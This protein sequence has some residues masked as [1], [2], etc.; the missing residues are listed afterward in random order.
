MLKQIYRSTCWYKSN[1]NIVN[2]S[3]VNLVAVGQKMTNASETVPKDTIS[4]TLANS[5]VIFRR[6]RALGYVS[7]SVPAAIRYV[8][9]RKDTLITT[10]IGRSFQV[11]TSSHFRL[12]HVGPVH[13]DE[14]TALAMDRAHTFT[15]SNRCIYAWRAGKHQRHVYR[16]HTRNV[17]L[18]LPFGAHLISVDEANVLRVWDIAKEEVYLELQFN[19]E[20]FLISAITHPPAYLNKI[21]LGSKQG[22]LKIWNIKE[23]RLVYTFA[24]F[25][26]KVTCIQPSPA[27]DVVAVGHQDGTIVLLNL[28]FDEVLMKF[29]QDWGQVSQI[30]FRTDGPPIMITA[31]SNGHMALWNLE[32]RKIAGQLQAHE[33][34]VSTAICFHNEPLLFTTSPDNSMKLWIFDMPDNG[35][36]LLRIREGHT[37][38]PLCIRFHGSNGTSILSAGE[39]SALRVFSTISESL[40]KSMGKASYNRKQSKKRNR[41]DG[42]ALRMPPII[43]FTSETTREREWDNIAAIH[44]G[45]IQTTTWSFHKNR[46]G[47]HRLIPQK[48]QNKERVDY[49]TITTSVTLTHCCNFAIIGYSS[50]DVE[51]FNIQSGLHRAS[52]GSPAHKTA[53]RGVV[54]DILNQFVISGCG[55]GLLKFWPFKEK[56]TN[57]IKCLKFTDG[58]SLMRIHRESAMLAVA[59]VNFTVHIIDVDTRVVVRKFEGHTAKLNDMVF[60]PDSR[61]L[62]TASMDSTIKVWDI[63]SSYMIDHFKVDRPCI[64]LSM[65]PNGDFLATAHVNHLGIYLWANKMLFNQIT[66]RSKNPYS[67]APYVGLPISASDEMDVADL[68]ENAKLNEA[69]DDMSDSEVGPDINATYDS[70][71]QLDGDLI[72]LSGVAA[73]RWQNLLDLEIIKK[74]NK[75]KAPPKTPKQA[76]FFLPTV[77]GLEVKFDTSQAAEAM[78]ETDGSRLL[79]PGAGGLSTLTNFGKMLHGAGDSKKYSN[80]IDHLKQLGP[81]MIDFE[82][83]SLHPT[84]GGSYRIMVA[85]LSTIEQMFGTRLNFELAQAYLSVFLR[86]Y[87]IDLLDSVEVI[88]ALERV[89]KAQENSWKVVEDKLLFGL[90]VVTALRNF[91]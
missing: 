70:P 34:L 67:V 75:P 21:V 54:S 86:V 20:E 84:S 64:S 9:R 18:L 69:D 60:S 46:M 14:I 66:L 11:Y 50:G 48:F 19:P 17:H 44:E 24:G 89:S 55:E 31:C 5:S 13:P 76:P 88:Q 26:S 43:E 4:E 47:E 12:L 58:I 81:S 74:R 29:K 1:R 77:A 65:S 41:F 33:D 42:D 56:V 87:G 53:V 90:G 40:N 45:I 8:R 61:W 51:R 63:P 39:D 83:K 91:V 23:N 72:T 71:S 79:Q 80:C 25:G 10:C 82:I 15:A 49:E 35:A 59:L 52:Y 73:S 27:L 57:H 38:P 37:G 2:I 16:G 32:D 36:R 22:M 28:K 6:N 3:F 62:I 7:N 68:M 30:S 78:E 85:F